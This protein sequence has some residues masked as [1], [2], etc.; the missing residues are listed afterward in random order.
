MNNQLK[1]RINNLEAQKKTN[2]LRK[3][4]KKNYTKTELN[5]M[6]KVDGIRCF[7]KIRKY[8]LARKHGIGLEPK[9]KRV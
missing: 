6:A 5:M 4:N 2:E 1:K 3:E 7:S 9:L 8:E